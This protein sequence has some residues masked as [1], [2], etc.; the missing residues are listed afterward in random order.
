MPYEIWDK[1]QPLRDP[2]LDNE[3]GKR[4][5]VCTCQKDSL[6]FIHCLNW[7]PIQFLQDPVLITLNLFQKNGGMIGVIKISGKN[8]GG[9]TA[10]D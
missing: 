8:G 9:A 3:L 7:V 6:T 5:E 10:T 2:E 1:L 4:R